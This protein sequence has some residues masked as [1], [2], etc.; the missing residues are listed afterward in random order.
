MSYDLKGIETLA[1]LLEQGFYLDDALELVA[2]IY[3]SKSLKDIMRHIHDGERLEVAISKTNLPGVFIEYFKFFNNGLNTTLAIN[4]ALNLT[5]ESIATKKF[6]YK[7]ISYPFLLIMFICG[8]CLFLIFS[9]MPQINLLFTSFN[10]QTS[11]FTSM[12]FSF[13]NIFP[14]LVVML[15]LI[16]GT[17]ISFLSYGIQNNSF[18]IIDFFNRLP[19]SS[20]IIKSYYSLK[21]AIYYNELVKCGYDT[22]N[23]I[24]ILY[25]QM[26]SSDLKMIIY[27]LKKEIEQGIL[28]EQEFGSLYRDPKKNDKRPGRTDHHFYHPVGFW[29]CRN[30]CN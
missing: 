25:S 20:W 30:I 13:L 16:F 26:D 24:M 15:F 9:L 7:K 10:I 14:F 6:L 23:I 8:F 3:P 19:G 28:V 27:E 4:Q 29:I 5:N 12:V 1:L 2:T 18:K 22:S 21:F 11:M 17:G